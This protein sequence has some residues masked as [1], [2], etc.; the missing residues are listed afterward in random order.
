MPFFYNFYNYATCSFANNMN[1]LSQ[2]RKA[3]ALANNQALTFGLSIPVSAAP[4]VAS[5]S[6][7]EARILVVMTT[8]EVD[9]TIIHIPT[10]KMGQPSTVATD[11][12]TQEPSP[13]HSSAKR[14]R[15]I[16]RPL[17][18]KEALLN[19]VPWKRVASMMF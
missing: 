17:L 13:S 5:T 9:E 16:V 4:T 12:S 19:G 11:L 10:L 7:L 1:Q 18:L 3:L 8:L 6:A 2:F 15:V 14:G